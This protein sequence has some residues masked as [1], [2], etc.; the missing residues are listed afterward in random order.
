MHQ[1]TKKE[2]TNTVNL[3]KI[4]EFFPVEKTYYRNK[5]NLTQE[6]KLARF[7]YNLIS[8]QFVDFQT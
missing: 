2:L 6:N 3:K 1:L 8:L 7:C 5:F 4:H